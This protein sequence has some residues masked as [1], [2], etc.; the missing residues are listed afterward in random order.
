MTMETSNNDRR[1]DEIRE[2]LKAYIERSKK[3]RMEFDRIQGKHLTL[4][5]CSGKNTGKGIDL[6]KFNRL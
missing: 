3:Y 6:K 5:K 4:I 1:L 2:R